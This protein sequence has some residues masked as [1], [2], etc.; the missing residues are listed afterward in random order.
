M[1]HKLPHIQ[2]PKSLLHCLQ[3]L[4]WT[5]QAAPTPALHAKEPEH[6]PQFA[7]G[8]LDRE[9]VSQKSSPLAAFLPPAPP[10]PAHR[11]D[12]TPP[13]T[14][15]CRKR[16]WFACA[17]QRSSLA[18]QWYTLDHNKRVRGEQRVL[19]PPQPPWLFGCL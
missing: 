10:A 14:F 7:G 12:V 3:L 1:L 6:V 8:G 13:T 19:Q 9:N 17:P 18:L 15:L 4:F 5:S 11:H 16:W 2:I